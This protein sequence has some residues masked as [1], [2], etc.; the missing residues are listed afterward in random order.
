M[1]TTFFW[2]VSGVNQVLRSPMEL[3]SS[4]N[5]RITTKCTVTNCQKGWSVSATEQRQGLW[6][7]EKGMDLAMQNGEFTIKK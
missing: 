6:M 5:S 2:V 7:L 3:R 4:I 1:Y